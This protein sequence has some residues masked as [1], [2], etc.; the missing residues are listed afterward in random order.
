MLLPLNLGLVAVFYSL[1][2]TT[3]ELFNK[4]LTPTSQHKALLTAICAATEIEDTV[5]IRIGEESALK[6]L[7]ER[8]QLASADSKPS[9]SDP[10]LKALVLL[11]AH[12]RREQL[13]TDLQ[14]DLS[15]LLVQA[16]RFVQGLV[17]VVCSKGHLTPA[18][19]AMECS[20]MIVQST[21]TNRSS[22]LQ[23]P[24]VNDA[25]VARA[26]GK[27]LRHSPLLSSYRCRSVVATLAVHVS[28][29]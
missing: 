10:H 9:F 11:S 20:Q 16:E 18:I 29:C 15:S 22:L 21:L 13:T 17:D 6:T 19:A 4:L 5:Q 24:N 3:V 26:K 28:K 14:N 27:S 23:L 2:Y 25:F 7:Y 8:M 12:I 1:A